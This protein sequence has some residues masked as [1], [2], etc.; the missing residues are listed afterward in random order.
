MERIAN[1][2]LKSVAFLGVCVCLSAI[3]GFATSVAVI[4]SQVHI[5]IAADGLGLLRENGAWKK[6]FHC[7]IH[8]TKQTFFAF[9]GS[10][11]DIRSG[12][13]SVRIATTILN[14][15]GTIQTRARQVDLPPEK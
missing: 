2:F 10:T 6:Q 5:A 9:A 3:N 7:K 13:D 14:D 4:R 15:S 8:S 1:N 11:V 12:F